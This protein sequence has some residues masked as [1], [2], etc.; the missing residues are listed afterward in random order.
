MEAMKMEHT[1]KAPADGTVAQ[2]HFAVGALVDDGASLVDFQPEE[3][4]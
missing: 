2:V 4:A 1:L 3:A